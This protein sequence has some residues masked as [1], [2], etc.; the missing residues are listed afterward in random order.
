[1]ALR[2][3]EIIFFFYFASHIPITLFIDLQALLPG[4]VYP[5]PVSEIETKLQS[6]LLQVPIS[7]SVV[8]RQTP[9]VTL[10]CPPAE[11]SSEM[12]R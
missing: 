2:L 1:M 10:F 4:H 12:V 11:R 8:T 6:K 3:L 9:T 7:C 5:Q